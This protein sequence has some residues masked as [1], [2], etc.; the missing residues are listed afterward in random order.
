MCAQLRIVYFHIIIVKPCIHSLATIWF[1]LNGFV[2]YT[3]DDYYYIILL[4]LLQLLHSGAVGATIHKTY[5]NHVAL[6]L[7]LT[8]TR[9]HAH[10]HAHS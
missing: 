7:K 6:T 9:T 8:H 5:A 3:Y 4:L 1:S 2:S 10:T